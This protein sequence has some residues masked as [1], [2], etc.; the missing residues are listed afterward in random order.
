MNRFQIKIYIVILLLCFQCTYLIHQRSYNRIKRKYVNK[1]DLNENKIRKRKIRI[2]IDDTYINSQNNS[3]YKIVINSLESAANYWSKILKVERLPYKLTHTLFDVCKMKS[4]SPKLSNT[5]IGIEADIVIFP[6][7]SNLGDDLYTVNILCTVDDDY[8]RF[9]AAYEPAN[10]DV[11]FHLSKPTN[12]P[13]GG[14][15]E[16]NQNINTSKKNSDLFL[17]Q[18][19]MNSLATIF[20]FLSHTYNEDYLI[21]RTINGRERLLLNSPKVLAAARRHFSCPTMEGVELEDNGGELYEQ[22]HWGS[23]VMHGD[24]MVYLVN[25]VDFALS[26]ITL[27]VLDVPLFKI[28]VNHLVKL[29]VMILYM[30]ID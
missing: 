10:K 24:I 5:N 9:Y 2:Y 11:N 20:V 22:C 30:I 19:F 8:T 16:I 17:R 12:R 23:R 6:Y 25:R 3:K 27:A 14:C 26:E 15:I 21:K 28:I 1:R 29:L 4:F 18:M 13:I 7:F